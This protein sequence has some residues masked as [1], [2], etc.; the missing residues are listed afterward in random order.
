MKHAIQS[1][2]VACALASA[3]PAA[4]QIIN[5]GFE[6]GTFGDGS[7]RQIRAGDNTTLPGWTVN[8]NPLAWYTT[9]RA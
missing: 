9:G 2:I 4:A 8:D 3:S 1:I 6:Q 7:V 5:G